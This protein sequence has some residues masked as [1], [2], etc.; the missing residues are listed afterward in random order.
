MSTKSGA[1][2]TKQHEAF[3]TLKSSINAKHYVLP[4][5]KHC[6]TLS[7]ECA[8]EIPIMSCAVLQI[9]ACVLPA[10]D[11]AQSAPIPNAAAHILGYLQFL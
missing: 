1:R 5:L 7:F 10:T 11:F 6:K 3:E 2:S 9:F 8:L 4:V